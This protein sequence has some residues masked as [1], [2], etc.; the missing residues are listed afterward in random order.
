MATTG[1]GWEVLN[2]CT[3]HRMWVGSVEQKTSPPNLEAKEDVAISPNCNKNNDMLEHSE[4]Q[5]DIKTETDQKSEDTEDVKHKSEDDLNYDV[6]TIYIDTSIFKKEIS[7][8]ISEKENNLE[9]KRSRC[10]VGVELITSDDRVSEEINSEEI[11]PLEVE[12]KIYSFP[13]CTYTANNKRHLTGYQQSV[14]EG[15]TY[16]C[17]HCEFTTKDRSN[18]TQHLQSLH[19]DKTYSCQHCEFRAKLKGN[20]KTH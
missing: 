11:D 8:E 9:I 17:P 2:R 1:C 3:H 5:G 16:C 6:D 12:Y 7:E 19:E 13:H 18:L 15:K 10:S 20:L 4:P 14:H